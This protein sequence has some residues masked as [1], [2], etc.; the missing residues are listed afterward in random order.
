MLDSGKLEQDGASDAYALKELKISS[1]SLVS[2]INPLHSLEQAH[3]MVGITV[4]KYW[5]NSSCLGHTY[6]P[7]TW[8]WP[9]IH[10][11]FRFRYGGLPART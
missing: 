9:S 6:P 11:M 1:D 10:S 4:I 5:Y 8:S 7:M 3:D 2:L